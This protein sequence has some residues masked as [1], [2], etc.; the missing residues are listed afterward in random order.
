MVLSV[1]IVFLSVLRAGAGETTACPPP[2][3][4]YGVT[5]LMTLIELLGPTVTVSD[6][7]AKV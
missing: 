1:R 4:T 3:A 6:G 5:A 7:S 2:I